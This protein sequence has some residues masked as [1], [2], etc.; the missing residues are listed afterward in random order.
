MARR[1]HFHVLIVCPQ[2]SELEA[3]RYVFEHE[4]NSKFK[5]A[6]T[7]LS[8][9]LY[10]CREWNNLPLNVAMV[11]QVESGG[12]GAM[13]LVADLANYFSV[14]LIAMTGICAAE[15]DKYNRMEYGTVVVANRTTTESGGLEKANETF[16]PRALYKE[17]DKQI[18]PAIN[19][20]V[21]TKESSWVDFIPSQL[22]RPSPRYVKELLL[23]SVLVNAGGIVMEDLLTTVRSKFPGIEMLSL[24]EVLQKVLEESKSWICSEGKLLKATNEGKHYAND[25]P[26]FPR[27][28]HAIVAVS[29]SIGSVTNEVKDLGKE[30][31]TLKQHMADH[32]IKAIDR[33]AH[34]FMEQAT[35]SFSPGL[36]V[37]MKGIS[38]YGTDSSKLNYYKVHAA[39]T[40]AA[41]LRHF[42]TQKNSIIKSQ[43]LES[44]LFDVSAFVAGDWCDVAERLG[45][46][47][48]ETKMIEIEI[49]TKRERAYLMLCRWHSK[50]GDNASVDKVKA[51][52][53][54]VQEHKKPKAVDGIVLPNELREEKQFCGREAELQILKETLWGNDP[55][56]PIKEYCCVVVQG[57][58]GLG[59]SSLIAK[60]A[61]LWKHLYSDGVLF[62]YAESLATLT[63]SVIRNLT[64][65]GLSCNVQSLEA[66]NAELLKY[67]YKHSNMLLVYDGADDLSLLPKILPRS[68]ANVHVVITTRSDDCFVLQKVS[69]VI[70]LGSLEDADAVLAL[71]TWSGRQPSNDQES[72]AARKLSVE[73]PIEKLPIALAHAGTYVRNANLSYKEYYKQLRD[74]HLKVEAL[75]LDLDKLLNYFKASSLRDVLVNSGLTQPAHLKELSD[76]DIDQLNMKKYGE[77][78]V[79]SMRSFLKS[80]SHAHL[81]WQM[82][83]NLVAKGNPKALSLLEYAS[84][85]SS[86]DIPE[87]LVR[88]LVFR[89]CANYEYRLCVSTLSSHNLVEWHETSEGYTLNI[90]P[91]VQSTVLERVKQQPDEMERKIT[92]VCKNMKSHLPGNKMDFNALSSDVRLQLASHSYS[93]AKH[94][95]LDGVEIRT[96]F[97]VVR[98]TCETFLLYL[99]HDTSCYLCEKWYHKVMQLDS[100][101]HEVKR[102]WLIE[103]R[104][105]MSLAYLFKQKIDEALDLFLKTKKMIDELKP[106]EKE[107]IY[108]HHKDVLQGIYLCYNTLQK[109]EEEESYL[110]EWM[111]LMKTSGKHLG[112]DFA[113]VECALA[114]AYLKRGKRDEAMKLCQQVMEKLNDMEEYDQFKV[115]TILSH[116]FLFLG[117]FEKAGDLLDRSLKLIFR[118]D[119][120]NKFHDDLESRAVMMLKCRC[121]LERPNASKG[122]LTEALKMAKA[123]LSLTQSLLPSENFEIF[124]CKV[125]IAKCNREL[126]N[127]EMCIEQLKEIRK[128]EEP[129]MPDSRSR[130]CTVIR[131]LGDIHEERGDRGEALR[132]Y[133]EALELIYFF[134]GNATDAVKHF[135]QSIEIREQKQ[136]PPC[137]EA[138]L[139]Y[140]FLGVCNL[141]AVKRKAR[142]LEDFHQTQELFIKGLNILL[143][144]SDS[145]PNLPSVLVNLASSY[146]MRIDVKSTYEKATTLKLI[147]RKAYGLGDFAK[148]KDLFYM[149]MKVEAA[150]MVSQPA[151]KAIALHD[152]GLCQI[153][154]SQLNEAEETFT[155][156][157]RIAQS[158][159]PEE[160]QGLQISSIENVLGLVRML[161][162]SNF[163]F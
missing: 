79:K 12:I 90:H 20:L 46:S 39:S 117:E 42:V 122:K 58:G 60:Y 107:E 144:C 5:E 28:D 132:C 111:L 110:K 74:E 127:M 37:V 163:E 133:K 47:V 31:K 125:Q 36:P 148:A 9:S 66:K 54:Y 4:T 73:P 140:A 1:D 161:K 109:F 35:D 53:K 155:E 62:F 40:S 23:Q 65:F 17:L 67:V 11:A 64:S 50:E 154:L 26:S 33:E 86:R 99:P 56:I 151:Q 57:M 52:L 114:E 91:L 32:D 149:Q 130:L 48:Y 19:E 61:L 159:R 68:S 83:I 70:A 85:L 38:D 84:F 14:G 120:D 49:H 87:K 3:A 102:E 82:D 156:S 100:L 108:R 147:A 77:V 25:Q 115:T 128:V 98:Y 139:C 78:L 94:V 41:F 81:T 145:D 2:Q 104:N 112:A 141:Q 30:M 105:L 88:P 119:S 162:H 152:I 92:D 55:C 18:S 142:V 136:L 129:Y 135:E 22:Y 160:H 150:T 76:A 29:A 157:L 118:D 93:L 59:K 8:C 123:A 10:L 16:E 72:V 24:D 15:E 116:S 43:S 89:E 63:N 106:D 80:S 121:E 51:E 45:M 13:N 138:G 126:G 96:C 97:D 95:L 101:P 44:Q 27:G 103:V 69:R 143:F 34:F 124:N 113:K 21:A 131:E 153:G 7:D 146:G 137:R 158:L 75:A 134:T 71:T 6:H